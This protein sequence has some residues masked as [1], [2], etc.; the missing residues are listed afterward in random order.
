VGERF[1]TVMADNV[2]F[3]LPLGAFGVLAHGAQWKC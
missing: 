2:N 1:L 3:T